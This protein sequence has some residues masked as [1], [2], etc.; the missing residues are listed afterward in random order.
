[1]V[2][3]LLYFSYDSGITRLRWSKEVSVYGGAL[4]I[5]IFFL[6]Q[7]RRRQLHFSFSAVALM[8]AA[9]LINVLN[10]LRF[11]DYAANNFILASAVVMG[12]LVCSIL[13]LSELKCAFIKA[14]I[15]FCSYSLLATYVL[16][17]LTVKGYLSIF[18]TAY[19]AYRVPI[20]DMFL[21]FG[22]K[23]SGLMRNQGIFREPGVFQIFILIALLIVLYQKNLRHRLLMIILFALTM[24][25]TFSG[26]GLLVTALVFLT[27]AIS[28]QAVSRRQIPYLLIGMVLIGGL[29]LMIPDLRTQLG[30]SLGK[31]DMKNS[32]S[33]LV[34]AESL[35]NAMRLSF[36]YPIMG[37]SFNRATIYIIEHFNSYGTR[38]V[39]GTTLL[40][41]TGLGIPL[42]LFLN[43]LL[44]RFVRAIVATPKT[45]VVVS[46]F[47][48]VFLAVNSQNILY[49][50]IFWIFIFV[51]MMEREAVGNLANAQDRTLKYIAF[52]D[53]DKNASQNR[54]FTLSAVN[55]M[56]YICESINRCGLAVE[57]ISPAWTRQRSG[58][59]RG[60]S[61][62]LNEAT[63]VR[64][65]ASFGARNAL[66]RRLRS[67]FSLLQM[68][69]YL[70]T[71]TRNGEKILVY[72]SAVL[73]PW[74]R[75]LLLFR[76]LH[77]IMEVEE[78]YG[79]VSDSRSLTRKEMKFLSAVD[80]YLFSTE[81]LAQKIN[82]DQKPFLIIYGTYQVEP[83]RQARFADGRIHLVYAGI[84]DPRKGGTMAVAAAEYLPDNYHVHIIGFGSEADTQNLL[85]KIGE[86]ASRTAC[87][88]TYDGLLSGE[89]YVRFIQSCAIGLSTQSP[90]ADFNAS[91]FP[92]KV[93]SYLA[94]GLR[95]VSIK[96]KA[97]ESSSVSDLLY[98]YDKNNPV[99]L[100][101]A[102]QQVDIRQPYDSRQR[103]K[104]LDEEFTQHLRLLFEQLQVLDRIGE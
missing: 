51:P 22:V 43:Y 46:I 48:L 45:W 27:Y 54:Y 73:I 79:D 102:I 16:L 25:S 28:E 32:A 64:Q 74:L 80:A 47:L 92:S 6:Y 91:S 78:I 35:W 60:V 12:F 10:M 42:G 11:G 4:L 38:D 14:M 98:Y 104:T 24:A 61:Y 57:I 65:F 29:V 13:S 103:I 7:A 62:A 95:V 2:F 9:L 89:D 1:M 100:A 15:V 69:Y 49:S 94:N 59:Y 33:F 50:N 90:D 26:I 67:Y 99:E 37:Q 40:L 21:A 3:L 39:T 66:L 18:P 76:N 55:K 84:F 23:Y 31:W 58:Y 88:V 19:N 81:L 52:F 96:I 56:T 17:P 70:L 77:F 8:V 93:L 87:R 5:A 41:L 83:D 68:F 72:H 53:T 85:H 36:S 97:L 101:A 71:H 30:R 82:T 34:R 63:S 44:Y 75:L 86:V 20:S